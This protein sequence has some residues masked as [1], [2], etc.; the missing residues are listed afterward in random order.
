MNSLHQSNDARA[1]SLGAEIARFDVRGQ[2]GE[3]LC[4]VI[5]IVL[6]CS[7]ERSEVLAVSHA[8]YVIA[9]SMQCLNLPASVVGGTDVRRF[10]VIVLVLQTEQKARF[11]PQFNGL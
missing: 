4:H 7:F 1:V 6:N 10:R 2:S 5:A 8:H 3:K 9:Q 11:A